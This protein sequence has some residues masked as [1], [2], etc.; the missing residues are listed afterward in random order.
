MELWYTEQQTDEVRFSIKVKQ[1]LYTGKSEFQDVDVF[2]SEEF[3]KFLTLDGLMM[4]TEKDEFIYHDMITHVAMATNPNI[5]KV[6][7]IGG[8]DG[9]TVRELTRYSHIEK[10]DMVEIDKLVV[11]VSREYLPITASKLDDPRVNLYFED[12]IRF[13]ADTKEIYDLILVDSTDPIGP[14]EG[15]FTTE[16]YQNCFNILSDNGILVNQSESPYY[17]QFSH[18]MKRAHK[19]I[20]NIFPISKVYQFHMP[21]YPSGHWLFGFASKKLDPIKDVDFDKWNA[22]GIKTKY[23]NPQLHVGCFA[24]PSYVQEMLDNE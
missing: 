10:I 8:G 24:L 6:L 19:K 4:V 12:G 13:V 1:H 7:V 5:K 18:E 2:E 21:T 3:G 17:D 14:G 23:Y 11:D 16:F 15:L 20:K 22:L 9:G